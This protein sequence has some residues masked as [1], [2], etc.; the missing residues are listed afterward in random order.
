VF[1]MAKRSLSNAE[2]CPTPVKRSAVEI[3]VIT[4]SSSSSESEDEPPKVPCFL[5]ILP[6]IP[7]SVGF[8]HGC[9]DRPVV[10][11]FG[12]PSQHEVKNGRLFYFHLTPDFRHLAL[13]RYVSYRLVG[14]FQ[15]YSSKL[16]Q[17]DAL[18][19]VRSV[20]KTLHEFWV[21][22]I[23]DF[24]FPPRVRVPS[25]RLSD[26]C[27]PLS[28]FGFGDGGNPYAYTTFPPPASVYNNLGFL[29]L[30]LLCFDSY[31]F[32]WEN[33]DPSYGTMVSIPTENYLL[34]VC[35]AL[36]LTPDIRRY[37]YRFIYA[38]DV[39]FYV[40]YCTKYFLPGSP[41]RLVEEV[42]YSSPLPTDDELQALLQ[43]LIP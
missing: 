28:S 14:H 34:P 27:P 35:Q 33:P 38:L 7:I 8:L 3:I 17:A 40:N 22:F 25:T 19:L 10:W 37:I 2:S 43:S 31:G 16:R 41:T 29:Q 5:P 23:W 6:G 1:S 13:R 39:D 32:L 12:F 30:S 18:V 21:K 24:L 20:P 11:V 26:F 4:S 9:L 36:M 15:H 42:F